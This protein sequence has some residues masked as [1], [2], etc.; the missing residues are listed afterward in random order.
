MCIN[1]IDNVSFLVELV[2]VLNLFLK[3]NQSFD[4]I[5]RLSLQILLVLVTNYDYLND[6]P[7]FD[8]VV[9]SDVFNTLLA[10]IRWVIIIISTI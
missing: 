8:H 9:A 10:L 3:K 4:V 6:N 5:R 7:V 1:N 2:S